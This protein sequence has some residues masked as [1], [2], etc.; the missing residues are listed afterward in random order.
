MKAFHRRLEP[1]Q[2]MHRTFTY[3]CLFAF[4]VSLSGCFYSREIAHTRREIERTYPEAR[5]DRS[6]VVS[7]GPFSLRTVGWITGLVPDEDAWMVRSYLRDISRVKVGVY[8]T[9]ALPTSGSMDLSSLDRLRKDGWEV[10]VKVRDENEHVWVLYRE[11]RHFIGDIY[12]LSLDEE[13]LVIA[14]IR[15]N[16]SRLLENVLEDHADLTWI[17]DIGR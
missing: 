12:V 6:F 7:L 15:G 2:A 8:H 10:A 14:R 5:F 9:R 16:L 17:E 3:L 13:E 4:S 1:R 11:R